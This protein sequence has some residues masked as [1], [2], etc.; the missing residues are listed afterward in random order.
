[1]LGIAASFVNLTE[2]DLSRNTQ[3]TSL[4]PWLQQ[5]LPNLRKVSLGWCGESFDF[6]ALPAFLNGSVLSELDLNNS[7]SL[8]RS[9]E[10]V[11][12][13]IRDTKTIQKLR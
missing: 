6:G 7:H 3:L 10:A 11:S 12:A 1:M 2:L 5:G 13:F 9:P 8:T 4:P